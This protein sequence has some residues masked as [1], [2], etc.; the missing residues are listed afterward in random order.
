MGSGTKFLESGCTLSYSGV[1]PGEQEGRLTAAA[2]CRREGADCGLCVCTKQQL[3][4][5][6]LLGVGGILEW[7]SPENF[8]VLLGY[9]NAHVGNDGVTWRG[10][11]GRNELPNLNPS[12]V[13]FLEF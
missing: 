9:F 8:I 4:L 11:I 10:M 1:L 3:R 7:L 6:G 12:C 5:P 2:N 13:L